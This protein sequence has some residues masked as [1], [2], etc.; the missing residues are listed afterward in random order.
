MFARF[1]LALVFG[2]TLVGTASANADAER[3][4]QNLIDQGTA[5]LNGGGE[6][7]ARFHDFI[8]RY[9]DAR[10]T[11]L[12]TLGQ[13][14]RGA[15]EQ[16]LSGFVDAFRE[17]AIAIYESRL[18]Q[19]KSDNLRVT[20]STENKPGDVIVN[21]VTESREGRQPTRVAVRLMGSSGNY[22]IVD[23]QVEGAWLSVEQRDQFAT[24]LGKNGGDINAL[25]TH[26]REQTE[27][28]RR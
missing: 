14:R 6:R 10:K 2:L 19:R 12:F 16:T 7:H 22:K 23:V 25:I 21:A 1:V 28:I 17:Y 13:Y 11:A 4:A 26:L 5:I 27:R 18:D 15:D 3:F 20:G 9:I 8:S 24:L